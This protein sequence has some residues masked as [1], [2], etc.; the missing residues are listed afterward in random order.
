MGTGG[1]TLGGWGGKSSAG[2][3]QAVLFSGCVEAKTSGS[4]LLTLIAFVLLLSCLKS[5]LEQSQE[6]AV[7]IHSFPKALS[8]RFS[9]NGGRALLV[10]AQVLSLASVVLCSADVA[11]GL[12]GD[13]G[14][15]PC[16]PGFPPPVASPST[17]PCPLTVDPGWGPSSLP[18]GAGTLHPQ[19]VRCGRA[20]GWESPLRT[21]TDSLRTPDS[22]PP[23]PLTVSLAVTLQ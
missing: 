7:D 9:S 1:R 15:L 19:G 21:L 17:R 8:F 16:C 22:F 4:R 18:G 12:G 10:G 23:L 2:L 14:E 20:G 6:M 5:P 3:A 13:P 11:L